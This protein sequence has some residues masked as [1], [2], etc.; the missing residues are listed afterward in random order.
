MSTP[1]AQPD[2]AVVERLLR[3]WRGEIEARTVYQILVDREPDPRRADILRKIADAESV[4]R[5]RLEARLRELG[6]TVPDPSTV[7]VSP[8]LRMQARV[9]PVERVLRQREAAEDDEVLDTYGRSTGDPETDAVLREIRKDER[10][11]SLAVQDMLAAEAPT[12]EAG[13]QATLDRI[14][15]RESWHRRSSGWVPDA[16]YGANDGLAAVFGIVAGVSGAT[17]ATRS[18]VLTAGLAG[19]IASALSM[20]VGAWLAARSTRE[21]AQANVEQERQELESHPAEEKEELS[22]FYQLKGL[23]KAD[24]DAL[25][26]KVG[27]NPDAMLKM[28]VTEEF[29]G[30]EDDNNPNVSAIAGFISTGVGAIIPVIP[31]FFVGGVAGIAIAFALSLVAHFAV[32]AAK[33]LFTL[34]SWWSSGLEMTVAGVVV[35]GGTYVLGFLFRVSGG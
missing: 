29:G 1:A 34:R 28:L 17:G 20:G 31:F 6:T 11:H 32:G 10:S 8:W 5:A 16:I 12:T 30:A 23:S 3:A 4:H 7:R 33:S 9:A 15:H 18:F 22:L 26:D 35:G 21:M 24:A 14:L 2:P 27:E 13:P 25:V 19:A